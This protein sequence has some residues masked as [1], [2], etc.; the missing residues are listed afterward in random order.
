MV[1]IYSIY[2]DL[3]V[4]IIVPNFLSLSLISTN[5][6]KQKSGDFTHEISLCRGQT[7]QTC[8]PRGFLLWK[9]ICNTARTEH[10]WMVW[11]LKLLTGRLLVLKWPPLSFTPGCSRWSEIHLRWHHRI[12][13]YLGHFL[14]Q[15]HSQGN[16]RSPNQLSAWH[17]S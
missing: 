4:I 3:H 8:V 6:L 1:C 17:S 14:L 12:K 13:T 10:I 7:G 15:L 2:I 11:W 9:Q 16:L 5:T